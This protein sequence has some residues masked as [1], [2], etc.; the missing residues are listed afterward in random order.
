MYL[1]T[2]ANSAKVNAGMFAFPPGVAAG[3]AGTP[4]APAP[5]RK[6]AGEVVFSEGDDADSV[7]EVIGGMLRLY[8]LLPDGRR[9]ITGFVTAGHLLGLAPEGACVYT[10]E[11]IT[12][13]SLRRYKR[14]AFD[15]L[16]DEV[17]GFAKRLLAVA[18]QELR[19]AQDQMLLLGRK[20]ATEK[21]ASFLLLIADQQSGGTDDTLEIPMTRSD[22]ADYLGLTIETVSR[23]LTKLRQ[24]GLI[25][26]PTVARIEILDR[27]RL[28]DL[29]AGDGSSC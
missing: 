1:E 13:V 15:R 3:V 16:I 12:E 6:A 27:D 29:A 17:P 24:D 2:A 9:Q 23:T 26:L 11:A 5:Q 4:T 25:A 7:Y 21:V 19:A 8:K 22:I 20:A 14:A 10:A 28:E 18:S